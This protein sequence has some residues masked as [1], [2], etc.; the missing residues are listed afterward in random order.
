MANLEYVEIDTKGDYIQLD[1]LLSTTLTEGTKY[2]MQ[3]RNQGSSLTVCIASSTPTEGGFIMKDLE[4][5]EY[6]PASGENLYVLTGSVGKVYL[7]IA[8]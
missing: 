7:N 4:K 8:S 3:V 5:F 6:T 2:S 1:T